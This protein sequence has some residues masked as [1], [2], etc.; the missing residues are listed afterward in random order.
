MSIP[1]KKNILFFQN[2]ILPANGG[3]PR[4]SDII[5]AE[6]TKRGYNC[7]FVFYDKDNALYA[8]EYKLK[9]DLKGNYQIFESSIMQFVQKNEIDVVLCQNTYFMPF[10]N[11]FRQIRKLSPSRQF[12]CF[13]HASPD[14]WQFSFREKNHF[15][16][17]RF[18]INAAKKVA[19]RVA[20]TFHNPYIK[21]TSALYELCDKFILLSDS[22]KESFF[23]IYH[24]EQADN[25]LLSIPNPLTFSE[26]LLPGEINTKQKTVLIVS[27]LDESQKKISIALKI[28]KLLPKATRDTWKL[29]IVGTGPDELSY[30]NYAK[31]HNLHNV[32]FAGQQSNVIDYYRQSSIFMMTSIWEGLPMS[33]LEAQQNGVVPIAFDNFS[34]I[35]DVVLDGENGYVIKQNNITEFRDKLHELMENENLRYKMA[36]KSI[37]NSKGYQVS[38]IVDQ[39]ERLWGTES[40]GP[41][42]SNINQI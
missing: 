34:S 14:Y 31:E 40:T 23:K 26:S 11:V 37:E 35:Y 27:R 13:L 8:D 10:I 6:L 36:L 32:H 21:T 7:Y 5:S 17:H 15:L 42:S 1:G 19:K 38:N 25:K 41:A 33:L 2:S 3:V 24:V 22:F 4:V 30:K 20:F 28:W 16:S 39:W 12:F 9:V 18:F 29:M